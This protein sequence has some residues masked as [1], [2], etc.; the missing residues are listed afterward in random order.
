MKALHFVSLAGKTVA[1]PT[2]LYLHLA[3]WVRHPA[4]HYEL[5]EDCPPVPF[6]YRPLRWDENPEVGCLISWFSWDDGYAWKEITA[7][8]VMAFLSGD[9]SEHHNI[10]SRTIVSI[11]NKGQLR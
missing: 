1:I 6:G 10:G 4:D 5:D 8:A 9:S 11:L 2:K 7:Y 3:D